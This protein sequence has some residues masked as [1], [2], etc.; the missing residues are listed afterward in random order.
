M[1]AHEVVAGRV[2]EQGEAPGV[3]EGDEVG[4]PR[5]EFD[6]EDAEEGDLGPGDGGLVDA[7]AEGG[8]QDWEGWV[9][10]IRTYMWGG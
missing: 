5:E 4:F 6:V 3:A 10:V 1:L 7:V 2:E 9:L 8:V